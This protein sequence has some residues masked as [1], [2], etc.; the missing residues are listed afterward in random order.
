M[1]FVQ[2][3]WKDTM[4]QTVMSQIRYFSKRLNTKKYMS[5]T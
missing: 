2:D 5:F 3:P 1:D 4:V